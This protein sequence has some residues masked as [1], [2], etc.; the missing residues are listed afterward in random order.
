MA[1]GYHT[2]IAN[3][4]WCSIT[5]PC[6]SIY[7]SKP[8]WSSA[9]LWLETR[10]REKATRG[11]WSSEITNHT[12][13]HQSK[14][15]HQKRRSSAPFPKFTSLRVQPIDFYRTFTHLP[16]LAFRCLG[17]PIL[18]DISLLIVYRTDEPLW[19]FDMVELQ[20]KNRNDVLL[21]M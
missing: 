6:P 3:T 20:R 11:R 17:L 21:S 12:Q 19:E 9:S 10:S 7:Q 4:K 5:V 1:L 8:P 16:I 14:F 13:L 2:V 18:K 15:F